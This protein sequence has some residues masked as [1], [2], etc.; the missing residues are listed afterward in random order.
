MTSLERLSIMNRFACVCFWFG[1]LKR[2]SRSFTKKLAVYPIHSEP[3]VSSLLELPDVVL[4]S[5]Q[6]TFH[7]C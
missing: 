3:M 6:P 2:V 7:G 5:V 4:S 1:Q